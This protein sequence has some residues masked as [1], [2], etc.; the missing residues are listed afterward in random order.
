MIGW[1]CEREC[2]RRDRHCRTQEDVNLS[3]SSLL[4]PRDE[5]DPLVTSDAELEVALTRQQS[6]DIGKSI[7]S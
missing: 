7:V 3:K 2:G 6:E 4:K 1:G 5:D